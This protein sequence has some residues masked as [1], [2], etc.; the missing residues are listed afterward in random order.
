MKNLVRIFLIL[1]I[2]AQACKLPEGMIITNYDTFELDVNLNHLAHNMVK[3]LREQNSNKIAILEFPDLRGNNTFFGKYVAEELTVRLFSTRRF[4]IVERQL[5]DHVLQEQNLGA[6]GLIDA[7]SAAQIGKI[8]GV[9]AIVTGTITDLG[10]NVRI[11][12]RIIDAQTGSV[13]G[14]SAVTIEK[15]EHVQGLI[16]RDKPPPIIESP[17]IVEPE[18]A[19]VE[20]PVVNEPPPPAPEFGAALPYLI[21]EGFHVQIKSCIR[22]PDNSLR[23][24]LVV[25][26]RE[27]MD[28]EVQ[29]LPT[30][31]FM[32][33]NFG[34]EYTPSSREIANK[35]E[36]RL[37]LRHLLISELPTHFALDFQQVNPEAKSISRLNLSLWTQ[38]KGNFQLTFRNIQIQNQP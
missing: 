20:L 38:D 8:L 35:R 21:V 33:D 14:V 4:E 32:Y 29:F 31:S 34:N 19:V 13:Y 9:D 30:Q 7:G 6:S 16:D 5:L 26:N 10:K 28:R 1:M 11:N 24:E 15:D 2:F 23:V 17:V 37:P 18:P 22:R 27:A 12:A 36:T 3:D 25:T